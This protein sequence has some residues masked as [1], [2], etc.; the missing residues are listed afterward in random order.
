MDALARTTSLTQ[1]R[2][3]VPQQGI[4][5]GVAGYPMPADV[6]LAKSLALPFT[7]QPST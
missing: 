2:L 5:I 6:T 7:A 1:L 4:T 3:D